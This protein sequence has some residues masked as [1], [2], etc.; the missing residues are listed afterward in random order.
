M[1]TRYLDGSRFLQLYTGRWQNQKPAI[2][3]VPETHSKIWAEKWGDKGSAPLDWDWFPLVRKPLRSCPASSHVPHQA[4]LVQPHMQG[5]GFL[6][7]R[8]ADCFFHNWVGPG[9]GGTRRSR[10]DVLPK[11]SIA[12]EHQRPGDRCERGRGRVV[13]RAGSTGAVMAVSAG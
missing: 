5:S 3:T 6:V 11:E 4:E 9:A 1:Q 12:D 2:R 10:P 13:V 7:S 8:S